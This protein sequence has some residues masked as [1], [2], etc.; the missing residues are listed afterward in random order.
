MLVP[1]ECQLPVSFW[2]QYDEEQQTIGLHASLL[3]WVHTKYQDLP[4]EFQLTATI[5]TMSGQDSFI[6]VSTGA[7]KTLC[8]VL[9]C[10]LAPEHMAII[11][12]LSDPDL[13]QVCTC[14]LFDE[15]HRWRR[16]LTV[17]Q[18]ILW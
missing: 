7:G 6:N 18:E 1:E 14:G 8:M 11:F 9:L 12:S 4:R 15:Q 13:W 2:P 17:N 10:L 3:L 5:T 16:I